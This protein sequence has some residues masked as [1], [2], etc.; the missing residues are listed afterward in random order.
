MH[1]TRFFALPLLAMLTAPAF[2]EQPFPVG[3]YTAGEVTM[4]FDAHGGAQFRLGGKVGVEAAYAVTGDRLTFTDKSGPMACA[5]NQAT[6]TYRWKFADD[7]LTLTKIDDACD[8][9]A[10][11]LTAHPWKRAK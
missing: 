8:G 3:E 11:D 6:G 10:G 7:T 4:Q 9:R 2:A 5:K 1:A